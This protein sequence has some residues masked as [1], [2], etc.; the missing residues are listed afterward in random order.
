M[1][2][3]EVE[4]GTWTRIPQASRPAIGPHDEDFAYDASLDRLVVYVSAEDGSRR[5]EAR[6]WLFDLRSGTWLETDAVTPEFTYGGWGNVPATAYDEA[7]VRTVMMGQGHSAAYDATADR[8]ETLNAWTSSKD[9]LTIACGVHPECR[10]DQQMVYDAVNER[11]VVYGGAAI[12]DW[13]RGR[14][15]RRRRAGVRHADRR[16]DRPACAARAGRAMR[17]DS[18]MNARV[19]GRRLLAGLAS[20]TLLAACAAS[21][22]P[23]PTTVTSS[24]TSRCR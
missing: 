4:T 14:H 23:T 22:S 20:L 24:G 10:Q 13:R 1:W 7:A 18:A 6:T 21:A 16:V 11:L 17:R 3:Y 15:G 12:P 5:F 9:W 19:V 2:S 8:W